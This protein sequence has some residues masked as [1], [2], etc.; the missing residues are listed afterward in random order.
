MQPVNQNHSQLE[1]QV[2]LRAPWRGHVARHNWKSKE[3]AGDGVSSYADGATISGCSARIPYRRPRH[4]TD[5]AVKNV[6]VPEVG[7]ARVR[8]VRQ[9]SCTC[10][11]AI[12]EARQTLAQMCVRA[13]V[14]ALSYSGCQPPRAYGYRTW[15]TIRPD[16]V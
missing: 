7:A 14:C 4:T 6:V 16:P 13:C 12:G 9:Q 15:P 1:I 5:L 3:P 8:V 2:C 10:E 11:S